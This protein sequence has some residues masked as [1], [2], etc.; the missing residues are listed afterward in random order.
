MSMS[1]SCTRICGVL[2][3]FSIESPD[4]LDYVLPFWALDAEQRSVEHGVSFSD[5]TQSDPRVQDFRDKRTVCHRNFP[6]LL[7]ECR[8]T[9]RGSSSFGSSD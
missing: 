2:D 1:F 3:F 7:V 9:S 4:V 5:H 6:L 8:C